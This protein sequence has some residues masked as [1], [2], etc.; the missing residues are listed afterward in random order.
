MSR[1]TS[2]GLFEGL[3]DTNR[4]FCDG[5]LVAAQNL[6]TIMGH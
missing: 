1:R 2:A 5:V 6:T 3:G 4:Q